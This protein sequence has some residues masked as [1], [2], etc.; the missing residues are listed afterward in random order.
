MLRS[1][2]RVVDRVL[3]FRRGKLRQRP[4]APERHLHILMAVIIYVL[5]QIAVFVFE[6]YEH[7]VA[8]AAVSRKA[9]QRFYAVFG[10]P[11]F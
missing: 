1:V 11:G 10:F 5:R 6:A 7:V 8:A 9:E 2:E 4:L 3:V